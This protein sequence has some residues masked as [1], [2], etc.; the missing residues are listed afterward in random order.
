MSITTAPITGNF[1]AD[2]V[3]ST[4]SFTVRHMGSAK[5][6]AGFE[7]VDVRVEVGES[8]IKLDGTAN[9]ESL[10]IR[11]PAE[12]R[13]H[14]LYGPDFLDGRNHPQISFSSE[15]VRLS[16]NGSAVIDG[17]LTIKGITKPFTATGTYQEPV[18]DPWGA[19]RT[20]VEFAATVD[21]RDWNMTWQAPLPKG[22][23]VLSWDVELHAHV[24]LV[25]QA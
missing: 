20:G 4:F 12:F 13:E 18:E 16:E 6:T 19:I 17:L 15:E 9:V 3:H 7:D 2:K 22:G 23:N 10:S 8:G 25:K 24:E 14:I 11:F 5:Y 21:R 1:E